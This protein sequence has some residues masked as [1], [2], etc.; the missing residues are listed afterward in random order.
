MANS[1]NQMVTKLGDSSVEIGQVIKV[2]TSIAQQTNL[3][4]LNATIEAAAPARPGRDS[5][6]S[7]TK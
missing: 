7:P 3:L 1:T 2:I 6:W 4:A 5:P